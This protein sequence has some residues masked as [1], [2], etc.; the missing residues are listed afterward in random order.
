MIIGL[1]SI[2]ATPYVYDKLIIWGYQTLLSSFQKNHPHYLTLFN[3]PKKEFV[4]RRKKMYTMKIYT[5]T[6]SI[7]I[8]FH[9][10]KI[11]IHEIILPF[12]KIYLENKRKINYLCSKI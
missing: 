3:N 2:A 7:K 11:S 9:S 10:T 4:R 5:S 1:K 12:C 8:P 6:H